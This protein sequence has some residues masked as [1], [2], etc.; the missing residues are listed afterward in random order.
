MPEIEQKTIQILV[1][2][3][4]ALSREGIARLLSSESGFEI[5]G[6]CGSIEE[7]LHA[8][9]ERPIDLVLL[10]FYFKDGNGKQFVSLARQHGFTGKVLLVTAGISEDNT[11]DLI[12]VG[13]S[14]IFLKHDS[15]SLLA[16]VVR[17]VMRGG[18]WLQQEEV[19]NAMC[20]QSQTGAQLQQERFTE[21]E[22][23]VLSY[24]LEGLTNQRIAERIGISTSLVKLTMEQLFSKTGVHK[25]SQLVRI[26]LEQYKD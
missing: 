4:H 7:A 21:R 23:Q 22:Q 2:D 6:A 11:A 8:I 16:R 24:V 13:I 3:D 5:A 17:H 20:A 10:D 14:G 26:V 25:R 9:E 18:V 19:Q 12:R 1:V 15:P